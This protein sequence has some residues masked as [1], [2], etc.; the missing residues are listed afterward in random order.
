MW[1]K[2]IEK[3]VTCAGI[4][5]HSGRKVALGFHPAPAGSGV[6]FA[7]QGPAGTHFVVPDPKLVA[8]TRFATSL[9]QGDVRLGTIEHVL[10]A[11]RGLEID[12]LIIEVQGDEVPIM[13][14]SAA[15]FVLLLRQAGIREQ[16]TRRRIYRVVKECKVQQDGRWVKAFP[17]SGFK[18]KYTIDFPHPLLGKQSLDYEGSAENFVHL[19]CRARTFGF[20][21]DVE[22]LQGQGLILGGSL[23]NAL[24]LDECAALNPDGLRFPDEPVRHKLLDF[25]GDLG[26]MPYPVQ[27]AFE[28]HCSGHEL[29]NKFVC[30][31]EQEKDTCLQLIEQG[32]DPAHAQQGD[33]TSQSCPPSTRAE[34]ALGY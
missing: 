27:G 31:L 11:V 6:K 16:K 7:V 24:V 5:L 3:Y 25:I 32:Q 22:R 33:L 21:H 20:L 15:S 17:S 19:L 4:G 30:R 9:V 28:V 14:G 10:A 23:E 18:V 34:Q 26:L 13:D 2:T 8:E 12:N 1:Q 29:N